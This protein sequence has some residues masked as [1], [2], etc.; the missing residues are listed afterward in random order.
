M[1]EMYLT[2]MGTNGN[3]TGRG[4]VC[5]KSFGVRCSFFFSNMKMPNFTDVDY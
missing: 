2:F 1:I 3:K 5:L 4:N